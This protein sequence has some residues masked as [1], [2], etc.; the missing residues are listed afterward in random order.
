VTWTYDSASLST[1]LAKVRTLVGDTDTNDQL[2]TDEQV[3]LVIDAQS[4]FNQYLAAADIAETMLLAALLKRVDRNSPNFG[5]QRSQVFQHCKDLA[6]NLRKKASSGATCTHY[7]TSDAEYET[8]TSDT[9]FIAP[10]FTRGKFD[11][12]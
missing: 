9:D 11:R 5:A 12:S 7:G 8:L 3:N 6:A 1:N 10:A 4:S 2:L